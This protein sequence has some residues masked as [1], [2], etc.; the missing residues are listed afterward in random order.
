MI[1][2]LLETRSL[3]NLED[4][5]ET[6]FC[7]SDSFHYRTRPDDD[8]DDDDD[9]KKRATQLRGFDVARLQ[10]KSA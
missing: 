2:H 9:V 5:E 6:V 4:D 3:F 8:D 10:M 1:M 7:R